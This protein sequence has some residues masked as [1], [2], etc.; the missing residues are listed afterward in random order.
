MLPSLSE[1]PLSGVRLVVPESTV[2]RVVDSSTI[3]L[4]IETGRTFSLDQMGTEIWAALA[5]ADSIGSAIDSLSAQ[6]NAPPGAIARD[7]TELVETLLRSGL[8]SVQKR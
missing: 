8:V 3:L 1:L 4:Q 6:Y 2:S 5:S 7:V